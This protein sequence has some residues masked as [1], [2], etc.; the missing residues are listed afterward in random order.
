MIFTYKI[1]D[2]AFSADI[3]YKNTYLTM[4]DY[5]APDASPEFQIVITD[6]DLAQEKALSPYTLPDYAYESTAVYRKYIY[7]YFLYTA[8]LS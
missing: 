3:R 1:A 2:V 6:E 7:M 8:V 5:L 4:E